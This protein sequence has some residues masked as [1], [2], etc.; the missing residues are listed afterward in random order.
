M[1][2]PILDSAAYRTTPLDVSPF[3]AL[4]EQA[5]AD[6]L[7]AMGEPVLVTPRFGAARTITGVF[8]REYLLARGDAA[9]GVE[10]TMGPALFT[11]A[12]LLPDLEQDRPQLRIG[13]I[14]YEIIEVR[15][16]GSGGVV[17]SLRQVT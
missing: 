11:R 17:L 5:D 1:G 15:P 10:A 12:A 4:V 13:A 6:I 14:D 16:D 8:E 9:A 2:T 7:A 3:A